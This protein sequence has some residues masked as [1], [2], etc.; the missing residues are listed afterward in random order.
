MSANEQQS[1]VAPE[2][3]DIARSA[4]QLA[5]RHTAKRA[6]ATGGS[7]ALKVGAVAGGKVVLIV[8]LCVAAIVL[9]CGLAL[10]IA[11]ALGT[12]FQHTALPWPVAP[13]V[14]PDGTYRAG[15]WA[16]SSRFG[17]R[18]HPITGQ[19]EFHDGIDIVS[20][21]GA[22]PFAHRCLLPAMIDGVVTYVGWDENH[23]RHPDQEGGGQIVV[24]ESNRGAYQTIYAHLEPYRLHVQLQG[25]IVDEYGRYDE[26]ADYQPIGAGELVPDVSD[27]AIAISCRGDMP[28][29]TPTRSGATITFLYDRPADCQTSVMWGERGDGWRGWIADDPPTNAQGQATLRWQTPLNGTRSERRAGDVALRFRASLVPPPPPTPTPTPP[30]TPT[31]GVNAYQTETVMLAM[32]TDDQEIDQSPACHPTVDGTRCVWQLADIPVASQ[33]NIVL[34]GAYGTGSL[35]PRAVSVALTSVS[36]SPSPTLPQNAISFLDAS[37]STVGSYRVPVGG[38]R[39]IAFAGTSSDWPL[40][41]E[42]DAGE[43][44]MVRGVTGV[45]GGVQCSS[46]ASSVQCRADGPHVLWVEFVV[47]VRANAPMNSIQTLNGTLR[48]PVRQTGATLNLLIDPYAVTPGPWPPPTPLPTATPAAYPFPATATTPPFPPEITLPEVTPIAGPSPE[49]GQGPGQSPLACRPQALVPLPGVVNAAGTT[50]NMALAEDAAH[51]FAAVRA[52]IIAT[53]GQDPLARLA[54]ALRAPEF[55]SN[56]PGVALMSWHMTGRAIDLDTGFPWRRVREGRLWRLYINLTDVTAIFE[57]HGWNRIPDRADSQEWWHY[58]YHPNGISWASAMREIWTLARL[59]T[60]FPQINWLSVGCRSTL[61][62]GAMPLPDDLHE[63]CLAG[64]PAF[65]RAVEALPGCG[66][67]VRPGDRVYQLES[68]LGFIGLTGQ[69]TGPHLHLGIRQRGYAGD[70]PMINICTPEWLQGVQPLPDADCWTDMVDPL[71]FLPLAP[72]NNSAGLPEG[73]PYQ[74]PPPD[75]PGSLYREPRPGEPPVGQYW[76]PDADGGRYGGGK[77]GRS[78]SR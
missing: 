32:Q 64:A 19:P 65:A 24:V 11:G 75:Y 31:P 20:P 53:A 25:R 18:T 28:M 15:G 50:T 29:F 44:L 66:P 26:Y 38:R 13:D 41:V 63:R 51:S 21:T 30:I 62:D 34:R 61:P 23:G 9:I 70:F 2:A 3:R 6:L 39:R 71:A 69:T 1:A 8:A 68:P 17:W 57:R 46:T 67:P 10:I 72:P 5:A 77:S 43:H 42:I 37:M 58:E 33:Q 59:Q 60:A 49:P 78:T 45:S 35:A 14:Q 40:T 54:D 22:C 16:I 74:L 48:S 27:G 47:E 4:A 76:S 73:A 7:A 36:P 55:R 56:K 12:I 52:E